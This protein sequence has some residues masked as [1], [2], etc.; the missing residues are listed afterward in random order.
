MDY[1]KIDLF[2]IFDNVG[3]DNYLEIPLKSRNDIIL[4]LEFTTAQDRIISVE[5]D[6]LDENVSSLYINK[7]Y[8]TL[9]DQGDVPNPYLLQGCRGFFNICY[10]HYWDQC[11]DVVNPVKILK[12]I[13]EL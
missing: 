7:I 9:N 3:Y 11:D 13:F 10:S 4:E 8:N 2:K 6:H 5:F 12:V 1:S